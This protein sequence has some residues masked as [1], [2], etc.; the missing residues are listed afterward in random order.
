MLTEDA[1][2]AHGPGNKTG[3]IT[4]S[5]AETR[6]T[7]ASYPKGNRLVVRGDRAFVLTD[8]E[9]MAIDRTNGQNVWSVMCKCPHDLILTG[10]VLFAGGDDQVTGFDVSSGKQLCSKDVPGRALGLSAAAGSLYVST[11][12]GQIVCLK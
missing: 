9:L 1:R 7:I 8:E 11:D 4:E 3:W 10:D 12:T 2:V 6:D 5:N